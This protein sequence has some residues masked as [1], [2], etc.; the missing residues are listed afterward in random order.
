VNGGT[1][2]ILVTDGFQLGGCQ[3]PA[4]QLEAS[5]TLR[6]VW[7]GPVELRA[8]L[9]AMLSGRYGTPE[10]RILKP[11]VVAYP[12]DGEQHAGFWSHNRQSVLRWIQRRVVDKSLAD[13]IARSA[14]VSPDEKWVNLRGT[15]KALVGIEVALSQAPN[16]LFSTVGLDPLGAQTVARRVAKNQ[17]G[18]ALEL[19]WAQDYLPY[20]LPD[21]T[22]IQCAQSA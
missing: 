11:I 18:A 12:L 13:R 21:A 9:I 2:L 5:H 3:V 4:F 15:E 8:D 7:P 22:I 1:D 10:V 20:G 14:N 16:I 6:L 17:F 19:L